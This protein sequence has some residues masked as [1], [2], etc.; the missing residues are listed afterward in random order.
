MSEPSSQVWVSESPNVTSVSHVG[1]G[2]AAEVDMQAAREKRAKAS[3]RSRSEQGMGVRRERREPT[4]GRARRSSNLTG[5]QPAAVAFLPQTA[6]DP[7]DL[8]EDTAELALL[9]GVERCRNHGG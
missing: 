9:S 1:W 6:S 5:S 7:D 4:A 2:G 3:T 8:L